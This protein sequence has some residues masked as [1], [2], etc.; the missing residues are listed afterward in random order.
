MALNL[1]DKYVP[2]YGNVI[3]KCAIYYR[4]CLLNSIKPVI[5]NPYGHKIVGIKNHLFDWVSEKP[6]QLINV[7]VRHF[8][9]LTLSTAGYFHRV[10][11]LPEIKLPQGIKAGFTFRFG[12]PKYDGDCKYLNENGV[13]AM[14][15]E[16]KKYDKVFVC[17][18]NNSF[19][20][21]L[22]NEYGEDKI[23][24]VNDVGEDTRYD[25]SG[26]KQWVCLSQCPIVYH[27]VSA[28]G[29]SELSSSFGATAAVYGGSEI[30]GVDN[31]GRFWHG[32]NYRW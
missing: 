10:S 28:I 30:V 22:K 21:K 24:S 13:R 32:K 19:I 2:G 4:H 9:L 12:D 17:S 11:D 18:N 25:M 8:D 3:L 29:S 16:F 7:P 20:Q 6:E 27:Q 31:D 23:Y 26:L 14:T 5:Y 1:E 15:E